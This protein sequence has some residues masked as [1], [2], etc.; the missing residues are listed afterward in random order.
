MTAARTLTAIA[1]AGALAGCSALAPVRDDSRFYV[2]N[3]VTAATERVEA[4][5]PD[6]VVGVGPV[7]IPEYLDR[8]EIV[9]RAGAYQIAAI[10]NA[11]WG[12]PLQPNLARVLAQNL[13]VELGT[14]QVIVFP[15]VGATQPSYVVTVDVQRFE[16][17]EDGAVTL[18]AHWTLR[19]FPARTVV[20]V[21]ETT[22]AEPASRTDAG[23]AAAAM[24]RAAAGLS[25]EIAAA[26]RDAQRDAQR[27]TRQ[28]AR[29]GTGM[30]SSRDGCRGARGA[31]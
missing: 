16:L 9:A 25:K 3:A 1:V 26:V 21:R 5:L 20:A 14:G 19:A 11:R 28:S 29:C 10:P 22:L 4:P 27:D 24:S 31:K 18:H 13:A 23:M 8:S 7:T 17:Q 2:L 30:A 15:W 6:L 12:E